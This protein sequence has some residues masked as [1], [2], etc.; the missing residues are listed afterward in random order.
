MST[1]AMRTRTTSSA[2][3][4]TPT[5]PD[6][7]EFA[8]HPLSAVHLSR[9][10]AC[11]EGLG[12]SPT[13]VQGMLEQPRLQSRLIRL[14][15]QRHGLSPLDQLTPP[16]AHD[17]PAS[18]LPAMDIGA[19]SRACGVVYWARAFTGEIRA[20]HVLQ[21]RER[22]GD[23]L[24]QLALN[25]RALASDEP[26][27]ADLETLE[28]AVSREG[29]NCLHA[30]LNDQPRA[31]GAWQRLKVRDRRSTESLPEEALQRGPAIMRSVVQWRNAQGE[32]SL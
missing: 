6:W 3:R 13:T 24:Y 8:A 23:A 30:W 28:E 20:A 10:Q 16:V 4:H 5:Q 7:A 19:L 15:E 2:A 1:S 17:V 14:L 9:L 29:E 25:S 22:F 32:G 11:F 31:L 18:M 12:L 27:P 21:L 26:P